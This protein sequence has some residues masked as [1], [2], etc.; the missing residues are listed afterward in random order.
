[1]HLRQQSP[2]VFWI[3]RKL[4]RTS[5]CSHNLYFFHF[6]YQTESI[7]EV[8]VKHDKHIAYACSMLPTT[9][10]ISTEIKLQKYELL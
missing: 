2:E 6:K 7:N 8:V 1:M 4:E 3:W 10:D 5:I 9:V